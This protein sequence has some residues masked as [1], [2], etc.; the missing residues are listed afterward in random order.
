MKKRLLIL[1][2]LTSISLPL[3][4][5]DIIVTSDGQISIQ[6]AIEMAHPKDKIVIKEGIYET[7]TSIL[8]ESKYLLEITAEGEVWILCTD[9]YEHVFSMADSEEIYFY[10][11]KASHK[12][13]PEDFQCNGSVVNI[14][15]SSTVGVYDCELIG[16]GAVGVSADN[17]YD[18]EVSGCFIRNN[19]LSARS[20]SNCSGVTISHNTIVKNVSF[21]EIYENV[22]Y[23]NIYGNVIADNLGDEYY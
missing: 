15:D 20:L 3:F 10:G 6:E 17:S 8:I 23:L 13:W 18:V 12:V 5:D 7:D 21:L 16:S 19:S 9:I 22:G 1:C 4:S 11:I 2:L 14:V